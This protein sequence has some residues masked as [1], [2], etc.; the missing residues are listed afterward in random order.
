MPGRGH[1]L[2]PRPLARGEIPQ[3]EQDRP[4]GPA[5][6]RPQAR[7]DRGAPDHRVTALA[8]ARAAQDRTGL[9]IR[10]VIRQLRPLRSATIAV[11][12]TVHAF[13]P[14]IEPE[15]QKIIDDLKNGR[16]LRH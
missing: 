10:N 14:A 9:A 16:D 15:Q 11:N 13:P 8:V 5:H 1:Q 4:G 12:G 6:V 7:R 3:D 2:L